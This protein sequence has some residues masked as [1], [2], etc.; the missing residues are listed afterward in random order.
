MQSVFLFFEISMSNNKYILSQMIVQTRIPLRYHT[1]YHMYD[2]L[3]RAIRQEKVHLF[4]RINHSKV[5]P[6][7]I[8]MPLTVNVYFG[9]PA[10]GTAL[11]MHEPYTLSTKLPLCIGFVHIRSID[12]VQL[13]F[14]NPFD[15]EVYPVPFRHTA[16]LV[17]RIFSTVSEL[18]AT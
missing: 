5:A 14:Y 1:P 6:P 4:G 10:Q 16:T 18:A 11:M 2:L 13:T 3:I 17:T 15:P 8:D 9:T 12:M 7:D